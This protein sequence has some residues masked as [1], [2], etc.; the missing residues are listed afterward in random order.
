MGFGDR[1]CIS[2]PNVIKTGQ[3]VAE[4]MVLEMAAVCHLGFL[5]FTFFNA[6]YGQ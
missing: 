3:T 6:Q 4:I 5:K 2:M 1:F